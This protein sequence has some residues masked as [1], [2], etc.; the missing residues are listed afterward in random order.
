MAF[1]DA[2]LERALRAETKGG[3][4]LYGGVDELTVIGDGWMAVIPE[5]ELRERLRGTLGA[6]VE[7]LG[8]IPGVETVRILRQKGGYTVQPEM[9]E[10]VAAEICV[11]AEETETEEIRVTGLRLGGSVLAQKRGGEIVGIP[12]RGPGLCVRRYYVTP[13]GIVRQEDED[14]GERLYR[15][16]YRPRE[17]T[18]TETALRR[19]KHLEMIDWCGWDAPEE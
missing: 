2:S 9:P 11:Y 12:P 8:Y 18:D 14:T 13:G 17:D 1:E 19:W 15:R 4:T 16:G 6:L 10:T 5:T 7:M 3:V